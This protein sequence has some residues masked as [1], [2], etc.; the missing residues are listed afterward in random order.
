MDPKKQIKPWELPKPTK[1]KG[2][3]GEGTVDVRETAALDEYQIT[4][5]L[6]RAIHQPHLENFFNAIRLGTELSCPA[7]LGYET[8]VMVLKVNEAVEAG[9][10]L[11]FKEE[12]FVV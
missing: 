12:D 7:E 9:R 1:V 2:A 4:A 11:S 5:T 6:D 10:T 8:A 3:G